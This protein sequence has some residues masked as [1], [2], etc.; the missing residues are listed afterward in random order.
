M[1]TTDQNIL[2][3]MHNLFLEALR[4]REQDIVRFIAIL[5]PALAGYIWLLKYYFDSEI[6]C[7]LFMYC[8]IGIL[9]I[10]FGGACYSI[11]LGYN[12]RYITMQLAKIENA[13]KIARYT[14]K[15]WP[16][17]VDDFRKWYCEPP[18]IIKVF[19]IAF[20]AA[21]MGVGINPDYIFNR[22]RDNSII[23]PIALALIIIGILLPIFYGRKLSNICDEEGQDWNYK[24]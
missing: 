9:F 1:K 2:Q 16:R 8:R 7:Q 4:H 21:I 11:T 15:K 19:W 23:D 18:E 20:L 12:Y 5:G 13:L 22:Y 3:G 17:D 14:L 10:L 24:I 6:S